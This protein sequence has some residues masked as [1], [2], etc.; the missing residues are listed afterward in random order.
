MTIEIQKLSESNF[1]DYV[2]VTTLDKEKPCYCSW[3]HLKPESIEKYDEEKRNNPQKFMDCIKSK[4]DTG[5]HVGVLAYENKEPVAWIAIGVLPEFY[6]AWK[7][8]S[9]LGEKA[10][11]IA[12]IMCFNT[13][14]KFRGLQK[15]KDVLIALENYGRSLGWSAIEGY[16][17]DD[18]ARRAH[19]SAVLW[20]GLTEEFVEA[21]YRRLASH[22]LSNETA[23]RSIF[24]KML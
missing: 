21:G 9:S 3:W 6:W 23:E 16:P 15:T 4:L 13:F 5:F 22:W 1:A 24:C 14:P 11:S 2:Y 17:F 12:G 18:S 20:P 7:R 8:V 19:G 10:Q